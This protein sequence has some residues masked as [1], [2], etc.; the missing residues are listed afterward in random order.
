MGRKRGN[1]PCRN[2]LKETSAKV[3]NKQIN[4]Q[5]GVHGQERGNPHTL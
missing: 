2:K 1:I 4:F 3:V 5:I